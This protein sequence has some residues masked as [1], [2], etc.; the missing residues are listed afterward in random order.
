[1]TVGDENSTLAIPTIECITPAQIQAALH[2]REGLLLSPDK[3]ISLEPSTPTAIQEAPASR[4]RPM[5]TRQPKSNSL[6]L[7]SYHF[8]MARARVT[9]STRWAIGRRGRGQG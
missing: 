1:M 8:P 5:T 2:T 3:W 9:P 7:I 4:G 6:S